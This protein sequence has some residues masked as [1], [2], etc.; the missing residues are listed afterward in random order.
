MKILD[1]KFSKTVNDLHDIVFDNYPTL[2]EEGSQKPIGA[3]GFVARHLIDGSPNLL[4]G[5]GVPIEAKLGSSKM[6][7]SQLK[8]RVLGSPLPIAE[9][10]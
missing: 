3:R 7:A 5:E 8:S 2:L 4:L 9:L 6:S 1:V 10:K